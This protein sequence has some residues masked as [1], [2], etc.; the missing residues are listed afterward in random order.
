[1]V[2]LDYS[3]RAS[4]SGLMV[5]SQRDVD[6][7]LDFEGAADYSI[8]PYTSVVG[9]DVRVAAWSLAVTRAVSLVDDGLGLDRHS[10][11]PAHS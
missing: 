9:G 1:M 6:S 4:S 5:I 11:N 3:G 2:V 8:L 10:S 7:S